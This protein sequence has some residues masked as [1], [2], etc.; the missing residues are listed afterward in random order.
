M[1]GM[2]VK[3]HFFARYELVMYATYI[4][5]LPALIINTIRHYAL[6]IDSYVHFFENRWKYIVCLLLNQ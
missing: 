3:E 5:Y 6:S 2:G 1:D 4:N